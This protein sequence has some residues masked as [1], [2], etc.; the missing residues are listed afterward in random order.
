M[1]Q[2]STFSIWHMDMIA[3]E[4]DS[5][6]NNHFWAYTWKQKFFSLSQGSTLTI[7]HVPYD[8]WQHD[9]TAWQ[10]LLSLHMKTKVVV[11]ETVTN[12]FGSQLLSKTFEI[13][14]WDHLYDWSTHGWGWCWSGPKKIIANFTYKQRLLS[15]DMKT[16][17]VHHVPR[18]IFNISKI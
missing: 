18:I 13:F 1:S 16:K 2:G 4:H 10:S 11:T 8:I 6:K 7:W 3:W 17:L 5:M 12:T 9:M 15:I 14:S